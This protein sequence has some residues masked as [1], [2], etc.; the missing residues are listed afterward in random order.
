VDYR[1]SFVILISK[2]LYYFEVNLKGGAGTG[3]EL[4]NDINH[5]TLHK[6]EFDKVNDCKIST[7]NEGGYSIPKIPM[8][9]KLD[10]AISER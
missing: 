2:L 5:V 6:M 9:M 4:G 10:Q 8:E 7:D 3:Y 1:F